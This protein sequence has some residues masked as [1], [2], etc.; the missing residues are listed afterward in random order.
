M[1]DPLA[2]PT[3]DGQTDLSEEDQQALVPSYIATRGDLFDAEQ[4]NITEALL[5]SPPSPGQLLDDRYLRELHRAMFGNVWRWAGSYRTTQT[6]IGIAPAEIASSVLDLVRDAQVWVA[7]EDEA[8]DELAIRFH[9][10]L[11]AIHPFANGNGRHGRVAADYL[12]MGLGRPRFT[13]GREMAVET[14]SVRAAY[15]DALRRA[16]AGDLSDLVEF[17]RS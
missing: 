17:A 4:R 12:V 15:L 9:H 6:N 5:R 3:G 16:D 14:A 7:H 2:V 10:R 11:V 8:P 13:W 1:Q